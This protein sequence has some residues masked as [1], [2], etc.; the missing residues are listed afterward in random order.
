ME[1]R[2]RHDTPAGPEKW[3]R[4]SSKLKVTYCIEPDA[5]SLAERAVEHLI[6]DVKQA[7]AQRGRARIALSGGSTP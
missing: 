5:A 6:A 1:E 3:S 2:S 7:V 4:M